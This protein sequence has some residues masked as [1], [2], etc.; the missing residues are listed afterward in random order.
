[1]KTTPDERREIVEAAERARQAHAL[2][3][4]FRSENDHRY[5][6]AFQQAERIEKSWLLAAANRAT[7]LVADVEELEGKVKDLESGRE[8]FLEHFLA[9]KNMAD[10]WALQKEVTDA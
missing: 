2:A 4:K 6:V 1:M 5:G 7:D 8:A 3:D 9:C 10:M